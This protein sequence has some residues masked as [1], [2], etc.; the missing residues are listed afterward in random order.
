MR[1]GARKGKPRFSKCHV[2]K[3]FPLFCGLL[4]QQGINAMT[5]NDLGQ[6]PH[7]LNNKEDRC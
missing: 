3:A 2:S 1:T 6:D 5:E 7:C 4:L